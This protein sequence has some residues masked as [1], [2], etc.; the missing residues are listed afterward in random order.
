MSE[1]FAASFFASD[2]GLLAAHPDR[3]FASSLG[4]VVN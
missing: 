2:A 1:E 4:R 3:L